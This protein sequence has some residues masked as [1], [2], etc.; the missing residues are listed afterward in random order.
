[1]ATELLRELRA[2]VGRR[3][4]L[5]GGAAMR[6]H[7]T[8]YRFGGG[9][10]LAVVRPG[11]LVEQW[12][13]LNAC[14]AAGVVVIA[15]AANTGLTGGSTPVAE[16]YGRDVVVVNLMRLKGIRLIDGG[17]QVVCL[18]G[19]TLFELERTLRPLG[20]EPHS[21]IGSSCFGASV[22]GGI[23]NNSGGALVQRGPAYTELALFARLRA[24]ATLEL[25]N[26]LGIA[27]GDDPEAVL[28]RLAAG[29]YDERDVIHD[30]AR[31]ASAPGYA[32]H[33]RA[34]EEDTPAR[35]NA[36]ARMLHEASGSA[37]R[38][39]LFAVRLDT[40]ETQPRTQVFYIGTNDPDELTRLRRE[41]LGRFRDLPIAAEYMHRTAFDIAAVYGK[42]L[43]L[44]VRQLGT[45]RL[46]ALFAM[47]A[48]FDALASRLGAGRASASDRLMQWASARFPAHLP[49]RMRD[50]RDR[51]AHHLMLRMGGD[52]IAEAQAWLENAFPSA[53]GDFFVCTP[54]EGRDA[55]LHRFAAAGAAVRYRTVHADTVEDIVA[56]DLALPRNA[57]DWFETLPPEIDG[58]VLFKLYYG[59]FFCHVFHQ[60]YIV[61]KGH[62][63]IALE[64]AMWTLLD[65]RG[66]QYPAEH[67]VGHLYAAKPPLADFYRALDP[68]NR[69]NPGIGQTSREA[70]WA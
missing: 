17:Q 28:E 13:V 44:A 61:A 52:G 1:M 70:D 68:C 40:F 35:Y 36:D 30:P 48:R 41:M 55:F 34:V 19:A 8:G 21:V 54:D 25:V 43:F 63:V 12:R 23:C 6:R 49:P 31:H 64:H 10:A 65:A 20:R 67:N 4:V 7:C 42:D 24:D 38:L 32:E 16:G 5:T 27:L 3:H 50:Y 33:V 53:D 59:H 51:Y 58:P 66:A 60:D 15:Q 2:I 45:D 62:D 39:M 22:H 57:T 18:P 29:R 46:P 14:V 26:H 11:T 56:L 69:L 9:A 47:K 37:G